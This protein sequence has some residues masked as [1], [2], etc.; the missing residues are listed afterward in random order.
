[1]L[2]S[3]KKSLLWLSSDLPVQRGKG[4]GEVLGGA[5]WWEA[6]VLNGDRFGGDRVEGLSRA[7]TLL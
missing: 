5:V 2:Y 7:D 4:Q 3:P 1:M 6:T